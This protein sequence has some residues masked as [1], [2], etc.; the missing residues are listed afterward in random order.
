[1]EID[2]Y[3][4]TFSFFHRREEIQSHTRFVGFARIRAFKS[5]RQKFIRRSAQLRIIKG[6]IPV[7]ID[8]TE[9][10]YVWVCVC[11]QLRFICI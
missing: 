10:Q 11:T 1:M 8:Q 9:G 5:S 4:I 2:N 3:V 7:V 6:G